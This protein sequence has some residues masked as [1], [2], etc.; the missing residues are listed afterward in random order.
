MDRLRSGR[1]ESKHVGHSTG[2]YRRFSQTLCI[3]LEYESE[4]GG[5]L[6]NIL[7]TLGNPQLQQSLVFLRI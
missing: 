7:S 3:G 4:G 1:G 2:V 6:S 5:Y